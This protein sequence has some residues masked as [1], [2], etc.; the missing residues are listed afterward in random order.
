MGKKNKH[1][2]SCGS[3]K[4][5]KECCG[6]SSGGAKLSLTRESK[7]AM[8]KMVEGLVAT[9]RHLEACEVLERLV[10]L[11]PRNPMIWN[12]LGVQYEAAGEL[13]KAFAAL[14]RGYKLDPN[15]AP[16]LY[17]LGKF[18]LDRCTRLGEAGV[19]EVQ[20]MLEEAI[21]F[22]N[23]FL[24]RDPDNAEGHY[25]VAL[26]YALRQD[27][28]LARAHMTLALRLRQTLEEPSGWRLG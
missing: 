15:Y 13:D 12:D 25:A 7:L 23:A 24:D 1:L 14:R 16:T 22:L 3:G 17:N 6:A 5:K 4:R 18:T 28:T 20:E 9:G 26:A 21:F 10:A 2:C 11:S 19:P 27:V 8:R